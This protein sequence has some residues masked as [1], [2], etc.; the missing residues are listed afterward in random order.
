MIEKLYTFGND[1]SFSKLFFAYFPKL[2]E[3]DLAA[4]HRYLD[5]CF[6]QTA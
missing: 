1:Y 2:I 3:W 5:N 4:F 6:F